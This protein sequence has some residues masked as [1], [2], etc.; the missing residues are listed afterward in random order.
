MCVLPKFVSSS[1][2]H[3]GYIAF[4]CGTHHSLHA[5]QICNHALLANVLITTPGGLGTFVEHFTH[6]SHPP[7]PRTDTWSP[8]LPTRRYSIPVF[9]GSSQAILFSFPWWL[10]GI[11]LDGCLVLF[12]GTWRILIITREGIVALIQNFNG[13][14]LGVIANKD[15]VRIHN[16]DCLDICQFKVKF[17]LYLV[18]EC[19]FSLKCDT[20]RCFSSC[21]FKLN[22]KHGYWSREARVTLST[23][24]PRSYLC[25]DLKVKAICPEILSR[26]CWYPG[27]WNRNI[28]VSLPAPKV[29]PLQ[30]RLNQ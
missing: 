28:V 24:T 2:Q 13:E 27:W 17:S 30:L 16:G 5:H 4:P 22:Q 8:E 12:V 26:I 23:L 1:F 14:I 11:K 25:L 10:Q 20:K 9:L 7:S 15:L 18:I 29:M 6:V 21:M 19:F 3:A